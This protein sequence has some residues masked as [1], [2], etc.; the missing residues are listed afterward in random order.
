MFLAE[1]RPVEVVLS[2]DLLRVWFVVPELKWAA[3]ERWLRD[4]G[5][6][7]PPALPPLSVLLYSLGCANVDFFF[8]IREEV[9][10]IGGFTTKFFVVWGKFMDVFG[11]WK[12]VECLAD[13]T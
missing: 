8:W 2:A 13:M 6:S 9:L 12:P 3:P 10:P 1:L 11:L 7:P 5:P 4:T